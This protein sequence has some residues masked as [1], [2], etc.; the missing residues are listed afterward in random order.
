MVQK[1]RITLHKTKSLN[2]ETWVHRIETKRSQKHYS[3]LWARSEEID[4]KFHKV[5]ALRILD[6]CFGNCL[7]L[8]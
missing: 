5:G 4:T 6:S 3:F 8:S 1:G 7:V 2:I